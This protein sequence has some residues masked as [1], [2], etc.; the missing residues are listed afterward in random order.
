MPGCHPS[1]PKMGM[2]MNEQQEVV[3]IGD[4]NEKRFRWFQELLSDVYEIDAVL[5][6]TFEEVRKFAND[7]SHNLT[8]RAVFLTDDLPFSDDPSKSTRDPN[9]NFG[10]LEE[11]LRYADFVCIVTKADDPHLAGVER[12]PH[13]VHLRSFPPTAE[14]RKKIIV[15]LGSMGRR[16]ARFMDTSQIEQI[17]TWDQ[18]NRALHRQIYALGEKHEFENGKKHLLHSIRNCLDCGSANKI[19]VKLLGQGKSGASV[20]HLAVS[21]PGQT[22]EYVL[23]LSTA[24]WKLESEVRGHLAAREKTGLPGYREHVAALKSPVRPIKPINPQPEHQFIVGSGQWYAI[25]YDFLGGPGF[26]KFI[27]LET[28]LIAAPPVLLEKT[29]DTLPAY[30]L[31]LVEPEEV[32]AH[33]HR[34]FGATLE[35]LCEIWYGKRGLVSREFK[36]IWNIETAEDEQF[37]PLPPYQLTRR[38][39]GWIQ[40]FLDSREA[41][42]G[43][44]LFPDWHGHIERLLNLVS[45][46]GTSAALRH[47]SGSIPFTLSPVHGDLNANNVLLWLEH[48]K[49]PFVIDLPFYQ[50]DGHALQDFARLEAEIKFAL[51]DRQEES[52]ASHLAAY[53]YTDAQVPLWVEMEDHLLSDTALNEAA[54]G[55]VGSWDYVWQSDGFKDNVTLCC[56]LI[57]LIR[58][59]ACGVQ[60]KVLDGM[61]AAEPFATEYLPSLLYHTVRAIGYPSLSV[62]KRLLAVRSSGLILERIERVMSCER[63][64]SK[65]LENEGG[66][67]QVIN[68]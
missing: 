46:Q 44:R 36:T 1:A 2:R 66:K 48:E 51:M 39:K 26:G 24:L 60:Q 34:I 41:A 8:A 10:K 68:S 20:F 54:L 5:A 59:K 3:L 35:G 58:E 45:G 27:D 40:D 53:D 6:H 31:T 13:H 28:T 37:I 38:V 55:R 64:F 43:A 12:R 18:N 30:Q 65:P 21:I 61:P 49:Y 57:M 4:P 47:L 9:L 52:P 22:K 17:I 23:K 33:R 32:A 19:E 14:D 29:K 50:K 15:E 7:K 42:I 11:I 67:R 63:N 16:L 62:F 25:H 56:K